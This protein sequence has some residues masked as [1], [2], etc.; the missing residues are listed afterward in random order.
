MCQSK[1]KVVDWIKKTRAYNILPIR[2]T[3]GQSTYTDLTLRDGKRYF[4]QTEMT[5]KQG[6]AYS[7]Q[8]KQAL[9]QRP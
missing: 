7:Y 8:I 6:V 3:L 1:H 4:M 2:F 9:K 5:R